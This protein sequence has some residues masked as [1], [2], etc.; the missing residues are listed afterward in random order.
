MLVL[1]VFQTFCMYHCSARD[2]CQL[3][4]CFCPCVYFV[5]S[6]SCHSMVL[7]ACTPVWLCLSLYTAPCRSDTLSLLVIDLAFPQTALLPLH[8]LQSTPRVQKKVNIHETQ[9]QAQAQAQAQKK[10]NPPRIERIERTYSDSDSDPNSNSD[11]FIT[12]A[13]S[14]CFSSQ[15][16]GP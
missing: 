8:L 2:L 11:Y 16:A 10:R 5:M 7:S 12:A 13:N 4:F 6:L 1:H 3:L 14:A 9:T 15:H